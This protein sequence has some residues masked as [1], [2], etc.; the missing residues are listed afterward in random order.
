MSEYK[1]SEESAE[2]QLGIFNEWY[3]IDPEDFSEMAEGNQ[4]A[5]NAFKV[6]SRKL[7]RAIR[8][9][10]LEIR[11]EK[12]KDGSPTLVVEQVLSRPI[13]DVER[14]KY[15]EVTG[16]ARTAVKTKEGDNDTLRN[17]KLL[18]ILSGEDYKLFQKLRGADIGVTDCLGFLFMQV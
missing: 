7:I 10:Y 17:Y 16:L 2:E 18:G 1:I 5:Q 9:G 14:V 13:E 11:E 4:A 6:V 8:K 15:R 12:G 3:D